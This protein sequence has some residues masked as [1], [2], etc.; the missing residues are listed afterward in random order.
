MIML[1]INLN[2]ASTACD[3][4][5]FPLQNQRQTNTGAG[6]NETAFNHFLS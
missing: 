6:E 4:D 5:S 2:K 3:E 1:S